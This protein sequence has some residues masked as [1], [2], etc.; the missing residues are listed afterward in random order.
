MDSDGY[1]VQVEEVLTECDMAQGD[2]ECGSCDAAFYLVFPRDV[3]G[4]LQFSHGGISGDLPSIRCPC[5]GAEAFV[6]LNAETR[7]ED[8][9]ESGNDF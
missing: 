4:D 6:I 1:C 8:L 9:P 7:E 2:A 3:A 5:C